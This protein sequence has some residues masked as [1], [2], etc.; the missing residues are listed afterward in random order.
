[1]LSYRPP[2]KLC[3]MNSLNCLNLQVDNQRQIYIIPLVNSTRQLKKVSLCVISVSISL[4]TCVTGLKY[5]NKVDP[6][7]FENPSVGAQFT[8]EF[9]HPRVLDTGNLDPVMNLDTALH[10]LKIIV[11]QGEGRTRPYDDP[12]RLEKD[13]YDIFLDLQQSPTTWEVLP[14]VTDPTANGYLAEDPK[15]YAVSPIVNSFD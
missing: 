12:Q 4:L 8:K 11:Y 7:L 13:H 14:V 15:I 1:M 9:Y 6:C 3:T 5:L 10:A 2:L